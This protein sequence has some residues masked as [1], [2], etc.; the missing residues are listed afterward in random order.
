MKKRSN[1]VFVSNVFLHSLEL[2]AGHNS[3]YVC[4]QKDGMVPAKFDGSIQPMY[5]EVVIPQGKQKTQQYLQKKFFCLPPLF[6]FW[7]CFYFLFLVLCLFLF[8]VLSFSLV[9]FPSL[10]FF[11][12]AQIMPAFVLS[13]K[14]QEFILQSRGE[15]VE[16]QSAKG[17]FSPSK[18]GRKI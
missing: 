4:V 3:H 6:L 14:V 16:K 18:E 10:N 5:D 7:F 8:L 15:T 2:V 1:E 9:L 12:E 13:V 17:M 11:L